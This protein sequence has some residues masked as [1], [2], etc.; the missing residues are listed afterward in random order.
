[1]TRPVNPTSQA[2]IIDSQGVPRRSRCKQALKGA[3]PAED[4]P[5]QNF[6]EIEILGVGELDAE[7]LNL[8]NIADPH[9]Y[10]A[11]RL[12]TSIYLEVTWIEVERFCSGLRCQASVCRD[13]KQNSN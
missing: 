8:C 10:V 3:R 5:L 1:M 6:E 4:T 13:E 11:S 2:G 7:S 12:C 9:L